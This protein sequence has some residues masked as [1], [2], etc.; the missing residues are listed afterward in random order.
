M[1]QGV[2]Y[3]TFP[4]DLRDSADP[5]S[6]TLWVVS[7]PHNWHPKSSE[8]W[9]LHL[10]AHTGEEIRRV[11]IPSRYASRRRAACCCRERTL[12][13]AQQRPFGKH[14]GAICSRN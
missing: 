3:G 4:G 1:L 5:T 6:T 9:L 10:D 14:M 12:W 2:Y 11:Q 8:E 7:R 13:P